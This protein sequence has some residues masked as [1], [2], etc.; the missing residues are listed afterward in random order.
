MTEYTGI[1]RGEQT[2]SRYMAISGVPDNKPLVCEL[3]SP[4]D[5]L[6]LQEPCP[7]AAQ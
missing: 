7:G 5:V 3:N 4:P 1:E 6:G 2:V